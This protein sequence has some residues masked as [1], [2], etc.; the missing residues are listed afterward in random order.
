MGA[1]TKSSLFIVFIQ[2]INVT[3]ME[4][5]GSREGK[6]FFKDKLHV[7]M[8]ANSLVFVT[9]S[10]KTSRLLVSSPLLTS[11]IVK[12]EIALG[13]YERRYKAFQNNLLEISR[14]LIGK[15]TCF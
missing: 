1:T 3:I 8:S 12:K 5:R 2:I 15:Y 14:I 9:N 6:M 4:S 10:S 11:S 7:P 13:S